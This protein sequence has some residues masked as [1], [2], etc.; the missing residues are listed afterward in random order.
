ME[1]NIKDNNKDFDLNM[2]CN[3]FEKA[4][5]ER[6]DMRKVLWMPQWVFYTT[7]LVIGIV[8]VVILKLIN[9]PEI[10]ER[11]GA[12]D[13]IAKISTGIDELKSYSVAETFVDSIELECRS[14]DSLCV[15]EIKDFDIKEEVDTIYH[16]IIGA[17]KDSVRA[18]KILL[19]CKMPGAYMVADSLVYRIS[20]YRANEKKEADK[21]AD[22]A[23]RLVYPNAWV[24]KEILL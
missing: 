13:L 11:S 2:D 9:N 21:Y 22:T 12:L 24:F 18:E 20:V 5:F 15:N 14:N 6:E 1:N 10:I 17:A 23:V 8:A 4:E 3:E 19:N 16:V 7:L